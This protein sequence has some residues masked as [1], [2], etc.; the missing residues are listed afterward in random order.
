M[1][2][3]TSPAAASPRPR[4]PSVETL[5]LRQFLSAAAAAEQPAEQTFA[6]AAD[7]YVRGGAYASMNYG[8]ATQLE[9]RNHDQ[10]GEARESYVRFDLP[11]VAEVASAALLGFGVW[12]VAAGPAG[13]ARIP[14]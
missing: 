10:P 14:F 3:T 11:G 9:V 4:R 12:Q 6:A 8:S 7:A 5:E 2:R 1:R 13:G